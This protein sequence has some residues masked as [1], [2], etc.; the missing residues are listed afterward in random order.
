M[1]GGY[2]TKTGAV[3]SPWITHVRNTMKEKGLNWRDALIQGSATYGGRAD[4]GKKNPRKTNIPR[5]K[6]GGKKNPRKTNLPREEYLPTSTKDGKL[7]PGI[8]QEFY[9]RYMT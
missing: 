6:D 7:P 8:T 4:G 5:R 1:N 9:D 2:G 3:N